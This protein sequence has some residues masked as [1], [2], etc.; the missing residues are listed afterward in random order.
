MTEFGADASV[1]IWDLKST[2][3][4]WM[5]FRGLSESTLDAYRGDSKLRTHTALGPYGSSMP[6]CIGPFYG[7]GVF[8][9]SSI[10]D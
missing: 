7:R 8:L 1:G 5:H 4:R 3:P 6:R 2:N 10:R 9:T